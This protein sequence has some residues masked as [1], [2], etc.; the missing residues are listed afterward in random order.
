MASLEQ[1]IG[2]VVR[3]GN[4]DLQ[5]YA[6]WAEEAVKDVFCAG[7]QQLGEAANARRE[8][9][10]RQNEAEMDSNGRQEV[11]KQAR[12]QLRPEASICQQCTEAFLFLR[13]NLKR[14][15]WSEALADKP[16]PFATLG[17]GMR[18]C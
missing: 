9:H 16:V 8:S 10:A 5:F 14:L 15:A 17:Q 6:Q 4:Y 1:L 2:Q 18:Q 3:A 13:K 12:E 7:Q 11:E